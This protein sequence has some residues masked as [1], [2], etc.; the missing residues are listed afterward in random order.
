MPA[1]RLP[2]VR[3][4][5][6]GIPGSLARRAGA[7]RVSKV[8]RPDRALAP[9]LLDR[10]IHPVLQEHAERPLDALAPDEALQVAGLH[11]GVPEEVAVGTP[12]TLVHG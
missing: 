2:P 6:C 10:E 12:G 5:R 1:L 11:A 4:R 7:T 8:P 3:A 9:E